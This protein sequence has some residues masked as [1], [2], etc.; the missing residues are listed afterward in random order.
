MTPFDALAELRR[1]VDRARVAAGL[2]KTAL[3]DRTA[4]GHVR[5]SR[6]TVQQFFRADGPLPSMDTVNALATALKLDVQPLLDLRG[7]AD[8]A[9]GGQA[10]VSTTPSAHRTP[11]DR[12]RQARSEPRLIGPIPRAALAFQPRSETNRLRAMLDGGGT[13]VLHGRATSAEVVGGALVGMGG[14]GKTQLAADYARAALVEGTVDVVVWVTATAR[15]AVVDRLAQAAGELC[16]TGLKAPEQAAAAFLAWLT[17]KRSTV[18]PVRWLVVLDDLTHPE[19]L[20][21]LWPPDSPHGRTLV[22]TRRQ[23]AALIGPNRI[24]LEVGLFTPEQATAH[25]TNALAAYGR[26]EHAEDLA[27]LAADMGLLPL[28][29]SQAAAYL[30]D[31]GTTV[32]TYR[33]ALADRATALGELAPDLLPDQQPHTVAAAWTL[34]ID[35]ADTLRPV[36][37]A[38]PL[39]QLAACLDPNGIPRTVLTTTPVRT[40]L[41][42]HRT[43][44]PGH[45]P[46]TETTPTPADTNPVSV[47]D[48]ERAISALRRLSLI[49]HDTPAAVRV[50]QLLQHAVRDTLTAHQHDET[51]RTA[52]DALLTAWPDIECDAH[53]AQALRANTTVLIKHAQDALY[54]PDAH[55][56]LYQA[57]NSLGRIGQD[58]AARDFFQY[59]TDTTTSYLGANH[60]DTLVARANLAYWQG[61]T[62]DAVGAADAFADLLEDAARVFGDDHPDTFTIRAQLADCRGATGDAVGAVDAFADLLADRTRVLGEDHLDTLAARN[63]LALWRGEAGDAAGA[64]AAFAD[65]LAD[66]TRVLV[67]EDHPRTLA[68]RHN[69]AR[70][71]GEAGDAA[72]AAAAF[73]DLLADRT[74]VL[75]EDHPDTL[76][77]RANLASWRGKAGDAAGAM[78]AFADLLA[79]LTR[80]LGEDHPD[81]LAA[82]NNLARW[83]GEA[84]EE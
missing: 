10:P 53:L 46:P 58:A 30:A 61:A 38:R 51:A 31:T 60:T 7:L 44:L 40:Y 24:C 17:P 23:D 16:P 35:H 4:L 50:H 19:E 64:A 82:R 28:A 80:V 75:G 45:Y 65:L 63:N 36:G 68:T 11:K 84:R 1:Q 56:V 77:T 34:S 3:A 81:T 20:R 69:L 71:R 5:I 70:W 59:L 54:R 47:A 32:T 25:L 15:S 52:A 26:T 27:A 43:P 79:D 39:L 2:T 6:T 8:G 12:P 9:G 49:T 13:A 78:E 57:G 67:D 14:V 73:A 37:L 48:T 22:T 76:I 83:R 29:L 62:G 41:A 33:Q 55:G 72:G 18:T 21:G 42:H 66:W 74:R